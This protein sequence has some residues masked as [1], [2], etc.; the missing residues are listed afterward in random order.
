[1][2]ATVPKDMPKDDYYLLK[3]CQAGSWYPGIEKSLR[4][5]LSTI[6][7]NFLD[8]PKQS[9]C[10]GCANHI[11][12]TPFL[13]IVALNARNISLASLSGKRNVVCNCPTCYSNLKDCKNILDGSSAMRDRALKA[14][15]KAGLEYNDSI[16]ITHVSEAY[17]ANLDRIKAKA[18]YSLKGIRAVTHHGC[19]YAKIYYRDV[20]SGNFERP[21]VIDDVLSG[22]GAE[23]VDY[24]ERSLCCGLGFHHI[25]LSPDYTRAVTRRKYSGIIEAD[26]DLLVTMCAGCTLSLD[27]CQEKVLQELGHKKD[28]PVVNISELMAI[29]LGADPYLVAGIDL[30]GVPVEPLLEKIGVEGTR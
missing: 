16:T 15:E 17:L 25:M 24:P 27:M 18:K 5:V 28:I 9:S 26:P 12:V 3:S 7:A 29:L 20:A 30:H 10:I 8:D 23:V 13:P 1:M 19:H 4:Y 2:Y 21:T 11:G 22:L 14:M 6:D